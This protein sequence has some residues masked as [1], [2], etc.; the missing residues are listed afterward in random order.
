[1]A[2][3]VLFCVGVFC[4]AGC[5]ILL[6]KPELGESF[7]RLCGRAAAFQPAVRNHTNGMGALASLT[8]AVSVMLYVGGFCVACCR[9]LLHKPVLAQASY[10]CAVAPLLSNSPCFTLRGQSTSAKTDPS[11]RRVA[12]QDPVHRRPLTGS[13]PSIWR[14]AIQLWTT[15]SSPLFGAPFTPNL[16]DRVPVLRCSFGPQKTSAFSSPKKGDHILLMY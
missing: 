11:C 7:L 12:C 9:A 10:V 3:S 15:C 1:M 6:D 8:L 13:G 14:A 2:V 5:R 4:A 16:G